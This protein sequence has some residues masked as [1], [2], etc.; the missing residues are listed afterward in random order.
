M[1]IR[2]TGTIVTAA[3]LV[4]VLSSGAMAQ[5]ASRNLSLSYDFPTNAGSF[6]L[7]IAV[8]GDSPLPWVPMT[9]TVALSHVRVSDSESAAGVSVEGAGTQTFVGAGPGIRLPVNDQLEFV[10]HFLVGY[11]KETVSVTGRFGQFGLGL[12][13]SPS[14]V[15]GR[16]GA[17]VDYGVTDG[18]RLRVM[19]EY[20]AE[21][22]LVAG[23]GLRF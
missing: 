11:L 23:V 21:P 22:H 17:G 9:L 20:V 5:E 18:M 4:T 16:L 1:H 2:K 14:G 12:E 15:K 13:A 19:F 10:A 7:G 8:H 6:P 3:A